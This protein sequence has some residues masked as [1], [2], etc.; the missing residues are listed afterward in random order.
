[1]TR[2][3]ETVEEIIDWIKE[4]VLFE[5]EENEGGEASDEVKVWRGTVE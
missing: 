2:A 3:P 5:E 1:L 4:R